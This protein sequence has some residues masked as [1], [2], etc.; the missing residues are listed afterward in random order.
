MDTPVSHID[1]E[2]EKALI[3]T[4]LAEWIRKELQSEHFLEAVHVMRTLMEE[5]PARTSQ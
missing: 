3:Q 4:N 2:T 1:A 5:L